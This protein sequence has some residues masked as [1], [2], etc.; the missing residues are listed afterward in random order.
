MSRT[1]L[2]TGA[3]GQL[4][5]ELVPLLRASG[6]QVRV[7]S[8]SAAQPGADPTGWHVVDWV[9]GAGLTDALSDVDVVVHCA[10]GSPKGERVTMPP[11]VRAA[12]GQPRPP[13]VVYI[14]IVGVDR[15]PMSYYRAKLASEQQLAASGL[16]Y[17]ILRATQFHSLIS[18]LLGALTRLPVVPLPK[19]LR[20]QPI[21]TTAVAARLAEVAV[22]EPQN[23]LQDMGGPEVRTL[24]SLAESHLRAQ[25]R[26]KRIVEVPLP[27]TLMA[28][29]R[30]GHNLAPHHAT[31]GQ[32]YD[33]YLAVPRP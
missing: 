28:A 33:E 5:R 18:A 19:A 6:H 13:H 4:G 26:A 24:R 27:G 23:G 20:F 31:P 3:T 8:R 25:G 14:S 29:M 7:T 21:S 2:V 10:S 17:S 11:L 1:V 30:A 16:P 15:L 22:G 9:S 12:G 32:T